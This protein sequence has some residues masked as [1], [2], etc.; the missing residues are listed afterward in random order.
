[1]RKRAIFIR[2]PS[3]SGNPPFETHA[4][5]PVAAAYL[6]LCPLIV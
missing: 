5:S 3:F 2:I 6:R 1:M 4:V